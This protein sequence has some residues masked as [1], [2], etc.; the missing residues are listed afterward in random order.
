VTACTSINRKRTKIGAKHIY[1]N[2]YNHWIQQ[3]VN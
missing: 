1:E 3:P 2:E